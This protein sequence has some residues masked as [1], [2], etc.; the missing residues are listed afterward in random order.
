MH[1]ID[2]PYVF[3]CECEEKYTTTSGIS[4]YKFPLKN[5]AHLAKWEHNIKRK[6]ILEKKRP[7]Q[8]TCYICNKQFKNECLLAVI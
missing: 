5:K 4:F 7:N 1:Y 3:N 2:G 8:I 6:G